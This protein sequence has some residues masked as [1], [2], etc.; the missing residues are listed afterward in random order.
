MLNVLA[1]PLTEGANCMVHVRVAHAAD[2]GWDIIAMFEEQVLVSRHCDDWH[3][4]ERMYQR[5]KNDAELN[6]FSL[7][8]RETSEARVTSH[9][10]A[11][12]ELPVKPQ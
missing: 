12:T 7:L 6:R 3:R 4:V 5:M 10:A 8:T 1:V 2:G 9:T 11:L